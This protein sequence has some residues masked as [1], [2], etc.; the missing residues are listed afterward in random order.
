MKVIIIGLLVAILFIAIEINHTIDSFMVREREI[1]RA[2]T[3]I[4]GKQKSNKT[5]IM[6][7]VRKLK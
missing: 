2:I 5:I 3:E 7:I 6:E 4:Y 1:Q